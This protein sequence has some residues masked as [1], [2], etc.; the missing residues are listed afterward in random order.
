[1]STAFDD[2]RVVEWEALARMH[3]STDGVAV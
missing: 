1:M 2:A 3:R